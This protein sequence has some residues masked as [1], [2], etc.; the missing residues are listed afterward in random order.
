MKVENLRTVGPTP[1]VYIS[2][3]S[4]RNARANS[5]RPEHPPPSVAR[6]IFWVHLTERLARAQSDMQKYMAMDPDREIYDVQQGA[7]LKV[8]RGTCAPG[9]LRTREW[10]SGIAMVIARTAMLI[11]SDDRIDTRTDIKLTSAP[12]PTGSP[13]ES[14]A[15]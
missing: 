5:C 10:S 7:Q 4:H 3:H 11:A 14:S 15:R 9:H 12:H 8:R 1:A 6:R 13:S 2:L